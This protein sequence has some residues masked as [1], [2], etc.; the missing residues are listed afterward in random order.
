VSSDFEIPQ[1]NNMTELFAPDTQDQQIPPST[2][3]RKQHLLKRRSQ[4]QDYMSINGVPLPQDEQLIINGLE[5]LRMKLFR[6][7][8]KRE[9]AEQKLASYKQE[10]F[11]L[12][13]ENQKLVSYR[14]E[15]LMLREELGTKRLGH[16]SA[17]N[18]PEPDPTGVKGA[19]NREQLQIENTR[20]RT[21]VKIL[22]STL[23]SEVQG[24][25]KMKQE[26]KRANDVLRRSHDVPQNEQ[27]QRENDDLRARIDDLTKQIAI[28]EDQL[29]NTRE[30][31]DDET[32][33]LSRKILDLNQQVVDGDTAMIVVNQKYDEDLA[34]A[35]AAYEKEVRRL[36]KEAEARYAADRAAKEEYAALQD[37]HDRLLSEL[38]EARARRE[39]NLNRWDPKEAELK[40]RLGSKTTDVQSVINEAFRKHNEKI[41]E[42]LARV[43]AEAN[44]KRGKESGSEPRLR[45][46]SRSVAK[47]STSKSRRLSMAEAEARRVSSDAES[48]TDLSDALH[49]KS[50]KQPSRGVEAQQVHPSMD[51]DTELSL[52]D[53]DEMHAIRKRVEMEHRA[54]KSMGAAAPAL[55][56]KSSLRSL[57]T[58]SSIGGGD[59]HSMRSASTGAI[60][61]AR[62][63]T[64][65]GD[66]ENN[67][68]ASRGSLRSLPRRRPSGTGADM[69]SG[70]LLPDL[71]LGGAALVGA[72]LHDEP[73]HD[74][75]RC[76]VCRRI[77]LARHPTVPLSPLAPPTPVPAS[78]R[79]L[80][81]EE[82]TTTGTAG[83]PADPTARPSEAPPRA[84]ARVIQELGDEIAHLKLALGEAERALAAH[85]PAAG[86]RRRGELEARVVQLVRALGVRGDQIYALFDVLEGQ[87]AAG[88]GGSTAREKRRVTVVS[89]RVEAT[90]AT[91]ESEAEWEGCSATGSMR[92]ESIL[93]S[94]RA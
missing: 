57:R 12:R 51:A 79:A 69:T 41:R 58:R 50:A 14:E 62:T 72:M 16:D 91:M 59:E 55:S 63:A 24:H 36:R 13:T 10:A 93:K 38:E 43:A 21:R 33:N 49:A 30:R 25:Q 18:S 56:R 65:N 70:F 81:D 20:L 94:I 92:I 61:D 88:V 28:L 68:H 6:E 32:Q 45:S 22:Q 82:A 53:T 60:D 8:K 85:D 35:K 83:A 46:R 78:A 86:R 31:H 5:E 4:A 15:V 29:D 47:A 19:R 3:S 66:D 67:T 80:A 34:K 73:P 64:T 52:P 90:T 40:I 77:E 89:P 76:T 44:S 39:R 27:L 75:A 17:L 74:P 84:L 48:T 9:E 23:D 37:E 26:L 71:T 54:R 1:V 87:R 2:R 11:T 7:Q 42:E